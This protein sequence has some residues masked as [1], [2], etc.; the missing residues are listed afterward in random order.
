MAGY[1]ELIKNFEKIRSY[2]REFYVYGIKSRSDFNGK[3][4]RSY[5][6]ERRRLESW[7]G[8]HVGFAR[9]N[10]KKNV[11]ISI[12]SRV[13]RHNPL[14]KAW[15][16]KSFTD[17]DVTL[18]FILFDI[19]CNDQ[20]YTLNEITDKIYDY[21]AGF[22]DPMSF[23]ESTLRKKLKEY[24]S[25]G[26]VKTQKQGKKVFYSRADDVCLDGCDDLLNFFSEVAPCGVV[27]SFL[28]D[29][30]NCQQDC[31]AFK[32]HYITS[33]T[34]SDVLA[35]IFDAIQKQSVVTATS[36]SNRFLQPRTVTI[37]PLRVFAS[38]QNGRQHL[39]AYHVEAGCI[40]AFRV[41]N[42][43]DLKICDKAQDF[44]KLISQLDKMQKH[45]W[46]VNTKHNG[47]VR[48]LQH[49]DFKIVADQNEDF[50]V[51]RLEREK[52]VGTVTQVDQNTWQFCA[53]LYDLSEIVPW[54]RTFICRIKE[55]NFSDEQLQKQ[56][57]AD[58]RQIYDEYCG[59]DDV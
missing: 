50:I 38:V 41:D 6:D 52:R 15:K 40:R 13:T 34:D 21:L 36:L 46:G 20:K 48:G 26:L 11:F 29:K 5:D 27:G 18:H 51:R 19:L 30:T 1:N 33:A 3:S 44:D 42:L 9:K 59:E 54:I 22:D 7:L 49:V 4:A 10:D 31:F 12:D 43:A 32:H 23:D 24:V 28:L 57:L 47:C 8:G 16:A 2:M 56:F 39:L 45:M 53:D 37:V 58:L 35:T 25:M 17:G 55:I 14:Y